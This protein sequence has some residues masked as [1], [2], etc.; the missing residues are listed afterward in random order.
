MNAQR[1]PDRALE[2]V[3]RPSPADISYTAPSSML[4]LAGYRM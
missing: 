1:L 4:H 2:I 3:L